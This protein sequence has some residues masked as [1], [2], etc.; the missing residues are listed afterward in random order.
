[1][2]TYLVFHFIEVPIA[3]LVFFIRHLLAVVSRCDFIFF[4][5][6][7]DIFT[8]ILWEWSN[9]KF[10]K[11]SRIERLALLFL[12]LENIS[13][14]FFFIS[15]KA[16]IRNGIGNYPSESFLLNC[17]FDLSREIKSETL[18]VMHLSFVDSSCVHLIWGSFC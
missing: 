16:S 5:A 7:I 9:W 10:L 2:C 4:M 8:I 15:I 6:Q 1:M 13:V 11:I 14:Y 12:I 17:N 18:Q 3:I